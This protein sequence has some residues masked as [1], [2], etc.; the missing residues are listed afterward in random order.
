MISATNK[1]LAKFQRYIQLTGPMS[2]A[3]YMSM[4]LFDSEFGYYSTNIPIGVDGDFTTSPE[5]SQIFGELIALWILETWELQ[6]KP[7]NVHIIEL[8][9]GRGTLMRDMIRTMRIRPEFM[10]TSHFH[11]LEASPVLCE[12]QHELL[13]QFNV[14]V[15]WHKNFETVP[16]GNNYIIA[17]EFFDV[18]P[19]RHFVHYKT[20]WHERMIGLT[21]KGELTFVLGSTPI[22]IDENHDSFPMPKEG[23]IR[24]ISPAS[25]AWMQEIAERVR[26]DGAALIIDYGYEK[27]RLGETFQALC[28]QA[29][30]SPLQNPGNSDLTAHVDFGN[31]GQVSSK[32]GAA[33][34]PLLTQAEFLI[35]MGLLERAGQLGADKDKA[36][37]LTLHQAVNRLAGSEE[38]GALFKVF[39]V[40]PKHQSF[41]PFVETG[42]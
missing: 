19:I 15:T 10:K 17:N 2:L 39:A 6:G 34:Q 27:P 5:I 3:E 9:P 23:D 38:M 36:F 12:A 28:N 1:M 30:I 41:S 22:L 7:D 24:E 33:P 32:A 35:K 8:G 25:D 26:G 31:L 42:P 20:N 18:L 29:Y 37:Q 16:T 4:C 40:A 14:P 11:C 21:D 13:A